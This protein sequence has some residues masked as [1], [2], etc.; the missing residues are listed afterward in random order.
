MQ[1]REDTLG[2]SGRMR[3]VSELQALRNRVPDSPA[4]HKCL[5]MDLCSQFDDIGAGREC[6]WRNLLSTRPEAEGSKPCFRKGRLPPTAPN[7]DE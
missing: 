4:M 6:R 1:H 7:I 3:S 2:R 5:V